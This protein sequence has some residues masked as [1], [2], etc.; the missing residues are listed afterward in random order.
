MGDDGATWLARPPDVTDADRQ[1]VR[2]CDA[3]EY[4]E[5]TD[6][7]RAAF[8]SSA[9]SVAMTVVWTVAIVTET[10]PVDLPRLCS[11]VDTDALEAIMRPTTA[12]AIGSDRHVSFTFGGCSVAV[13]SYGVVAVRPLRSADRS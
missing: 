9:D 2:E 4:D 1:S 7:Y 10:D 12:S 5:E 11:V 8:D 13:H 3:I 6:T